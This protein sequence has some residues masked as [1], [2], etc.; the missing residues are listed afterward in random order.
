MDARELFHQMLMARSNPE[1]S[2]NAL[3]WLIGRD[4][5]MIR[6]EEKKPEQQQEGAA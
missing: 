4:D 6:D 1:H 2:Y 3:C 5:L